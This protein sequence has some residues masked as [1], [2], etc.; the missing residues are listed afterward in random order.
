MK[1]VIQFEKLIIENFASFYG[2]HDFMFND[3][4]VHRIVGHNYDFKENE[5][6][7]SDDDIT[8]IHNNGSGKSQLTKSIDYAI[9][10]NSPNKKVN[11]DGLIN[12][13]SN[14][15]MLVGITFLKDG[16][17][18]EI[19][20]YRKYS[21]KGDQLSFI[22]WDENNV[23]YD[24][25]LSDKNL[26]QE[27]INS[28]IGLNR[29]T[30]IKTV[31]MSKEG[32]RNFFELPASERTSLIENIIRLDKFKE[33][34]QKIKEKLSFAKKELTRIQTIYIETN[35]KFKTV[36][37]FIKKEI[38]MERKRRTDLKI[39]KEKLEK[40]NHL[41][42]DDKTVDN[43]NLYIDTYK[44]IIDVNN[45][46][47]VNMTSLKVSKENIQYIYNSVME[48]RR[49]KINL[50]SS[51]DDKNSILLCQH[52]GKDPDGRHEK[53]IEKIQ[54]QIADISIKTSLKK[55]KQPIETVKQIK[56]KIDDYKI[57]LERLKEELKKI[58]LDKEIKNDIVKNNGRCE[59]L[60]KIKIFLK[61][62]EDLEKQMDIKKDITHYWQ[63]RIISRTENKKA[64]TKKTSLEEEIQIGELWNTILDYRH[65][66]SI[67]KFL[68]KKIVPVYN[69][70][71]N[72][73]L[74]IV[75]QGKLTCVFND[76]F[77]ETII[78]NG[79]DYDYEQLSTGEKTKLNIAINLAILNLM[80]INIGGANI[81][82][83]DELFSSID[84]AS[85]NKYLNILKE[86]YPEIGIY[87]IS[88]ESGA[89][90]FKFNSDI[91]IEKRNQ[92]SKIII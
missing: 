3:S 8:V 87:V 29:E 41:Q 46:V 61:R 16:Q 32:H 5:I 30:F 17:R 92:R 50:V 37:Q 59:L 91:V 28:V 48:H 6:N 83:I 88:H 14:K 77:E 42:I 18:Y 86:S 85:I 69:N 45:N 35:S 19:M 70:I 89:D 10:G 58:S 84:T 60:N 57:E 21:G 44:K 82:F 11:K 22:R 40:E 12:K 65:D 4:G 64:S 56:Q 81:L 72:A 33:Y 39:E 31:L 78:Y 75:F 73:I 13:E 53:H 90:L 52:C 9:Y 68:L 27:K 15:N 62:K 38:G 67:K 49:A 76:I 2:R 36:N 79:H 51:L 66:D 55:I 23:E 63:E 54:K 7:E 20:R 71:L 74:D 80:R 25:T 24:E 47:M 34:T 26:T 43:I 1:S